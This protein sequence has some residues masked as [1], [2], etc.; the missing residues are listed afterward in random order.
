MNTDIQTERDFLI[1]TYRSFNARDIDAVLAHMHTGVDWP[2]GMEGG[3]VYG[4]EAVREYW[5]RQFGLINSRVEPVRFEKDESGRIVVD[6]HQVVCDLTGNVIRDEM[7]EHVYL[8]E[9]GLIKSMEIR[10]PAD[11]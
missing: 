3:R 1:E 6:V 7:V 8:I 4:L 5:T 9:D 11:S 2:N 10:K